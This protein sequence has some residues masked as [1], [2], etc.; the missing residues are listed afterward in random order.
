M[1]NKKN[2][3]SDTKNIKQMAEQNNER[4]IITS[5]NNDYVLYNNKNGK[6]SHPKKLTEK[7]LTEL[8]DKKTPVG[9]RNMSRVQ[10][11]DIMGVLGPG[12]LKYKPA[13]KK[14]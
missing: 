8:R 4:F 12:K 14:P 7:T 10:I 13:S 2:I 9:F 5:I 6:W 1:D 3:S 11:N